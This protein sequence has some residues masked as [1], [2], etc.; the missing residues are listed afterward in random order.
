M[1]REQFLEDVE[2]INAEINALKNQAR[3]LADDYL[4]AQTLPV[5]TKIKHEGKV[6]EV[7]GTSFSWADGGNIHYFARYVDNPELS[8]GLRLGD[9]FEIVE[10]VLD[11]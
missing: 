4:A 8:K 1:T 7:L 2:A 5:G 9:D 11:T 3:K 10:E 6:F